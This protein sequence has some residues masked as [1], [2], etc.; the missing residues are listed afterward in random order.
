MKRFVLLL[1]CLSIM[2]LPLLFNASFAS[3]EWSPKRPATI[4]AKE[5]TSVYAYSYP[6]KKVIDTLPNGTVVDLLE[7]STDGQHYRVLYANGT[8]AGWVACSNLAFGGK[9]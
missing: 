8:K 7:F 4:Q 5:S 2:L 1:L 3:A 6:M 9:K